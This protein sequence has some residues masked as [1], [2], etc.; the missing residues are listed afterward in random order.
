MNTTSFLTRQSVLGVLL[1]ALGCAT[2]LLIQ[3]AR[4]TPPCSR[5]LRT[6]GRSPAEASRDYCSGSGC[7]EPTLVEIPGHCTSWWA[8]WA[9]PSPL[10]AVGIPLGIAVDAAL[11]AV[12]IPVGFPVV[13]ILVITGA[14]LPGGC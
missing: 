2:P 5:P 1:S 9:T 3:E 8:W 14:D 10:A 6:E 11:V 13:M 4:K 12:V 7:E